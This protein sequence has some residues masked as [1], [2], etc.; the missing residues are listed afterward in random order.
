[1]ALFQRAPLK[2]RTTPFPASFTVRIELATRNA[3]TDA[4][5]MA[6]NS[7]GS[8]WR[9]TSIL[10]PARM[11]LPKTQP[12]MTRNPIPLITLAPFLSPGL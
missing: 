7:C 4:P 8:A 12:T 2:A 5:A 6:I 11:K 3:P 9:M 1:M 10:P